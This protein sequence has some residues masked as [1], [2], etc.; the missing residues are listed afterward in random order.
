MLCLSQTLTLL[1]NDIININNMESG[2]SI[3]DSTLNKG[4]PS[5]VGILI[6]Q[7]VS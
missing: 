3:N 6:S 4:F 1:L 7:S 2:K 5:D